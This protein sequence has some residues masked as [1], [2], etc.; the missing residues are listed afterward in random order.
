[1]YFVLSCSEDGEVYVS[2]KTDDEIYDWLSSE[3]V[4]GAEF[5]SMADLLKEHDPQYWGRKKFIIKGEVIQPIVKTV[6]YRLP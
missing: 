4:E 2:P 1:M 6:A 5:G 3:E